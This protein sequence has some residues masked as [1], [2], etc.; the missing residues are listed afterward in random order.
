MT[1]AVK[2]THF[3]GHVTPPPKDAVGVREV[4]A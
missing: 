1:H 2:H 3:V 4:R